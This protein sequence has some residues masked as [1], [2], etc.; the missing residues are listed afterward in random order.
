MPAFSVRE[1]RRA[2]AAPHR[3][4]CR[5]LGFPIPSLL[6]PMPSPVNGCS[7]QPPSQSSHTIGPSGRYGD[8]CAQIRLLPVAL[9][10]DSFPSVSMLSPFLSNQS[11]QDSLHFLNAHIYVLDHSSIEH[12]RRHMPPPTLLLQVVEALQNDA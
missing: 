5:P 1:R 3:V 2:S 11:R 9:P 4:W 12:A 6:H 8:R 7:D 10:S